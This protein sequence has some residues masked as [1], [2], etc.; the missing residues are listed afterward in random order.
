MLS[1]G[2]AVNV[3]QKAAID[4]QLV[5]IVRKYA[6]PENIVLQLG[7]TLITRQSKSFREIEL[8]I[9][10]VAATN[11]YCPKR[12]RQKIKIGSSY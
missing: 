4:K 1:D 9:V 10:R 8:S 12:F 2:G 5:E 3:I 7:H 6:K 11:Q